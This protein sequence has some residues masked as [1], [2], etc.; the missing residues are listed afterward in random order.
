MYSFFLEIENEFSGSPYLNATPLVRAKP[1]KPA[2]QAQVEV[3]A[4]ISPF[5]ID[6]VSV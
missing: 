3:T 1:C 5:K 2:S 4:K 6:S